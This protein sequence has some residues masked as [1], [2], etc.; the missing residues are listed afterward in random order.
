MTITLPVRTILSHPERFASGAAVFGVLLLSDDDFRLLHCEYDG[1]S[2]DEGAALRIDDPL[3]AEKI[4]AAL[5]PSPAGGC[6]YFGRAL[7]D[8]STRWGPDGWVLHDVAY[9][10]LEESAPRSPQFVEVRSKPWG[11]EESE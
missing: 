5:P 2:F 11:W 3:A 9:L 8:A 7:F 1:G 10:W 4:R 6:C